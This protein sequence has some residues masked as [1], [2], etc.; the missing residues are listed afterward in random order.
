VGRRRHPQREYLW[1][2]A[3]TPQID[4]SLYEALREKA[5]AQGF[6]VSRLVRTVQPGA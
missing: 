4:A 5:R 1:I 6:D 3:R 2:L